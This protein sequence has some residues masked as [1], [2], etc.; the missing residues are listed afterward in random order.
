MHSADCRYTGKEKEREQEDTLLST[1]FPNFFAILFLFLRSAEFDPT[2]N[3]IISTSFD[4]TICIYDINEK[5]IL[6]K[7]L[8]HTDRVVLAKFH[9]FLPFILSTSADF[10]SRIFA[11]RDSIQTY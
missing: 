8:N 9:P 10:T 2:G 11:P 3:Y 6:S 7:L 4:K 1:I 5:R